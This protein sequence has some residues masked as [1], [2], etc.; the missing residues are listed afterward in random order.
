MFIVEKQPKSIAAESYR[1]L[2]TN[3]QYSSFDK[4]YKVI[5]VTSSEPG[6]GKSTTAGN[7]AL[8]LA[9]G[10]K[11]VILVDCDLRK[12]S[13]HKKFKVS[14]II[15]LSDVIIGKEELVTAF[16][17][18][19][20]NLVILTS[21]K[22]P[23]NP[24]EMLSSKTMTVLLEELK[25]NFDYIILDTPPVQ[26]VTDSQ[27]LSTKSDGTII[28]VKAERTKKDSVENSINLLKKVN[29]NI[30]GTVLNGVDNSRNKY[31]YYYGEK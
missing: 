26:A 11:K 30:I 7:L 23:P 9:Q 19:N 8:C 20:K 24:S 5:M 29:A 15:G 18:Y 3:I 16:H 6:E 17:R 27:I 10:D 28:V 12:P 25:N 21:G 1:T 2:R 22:I 14:N 4:E 31:Y 13:L